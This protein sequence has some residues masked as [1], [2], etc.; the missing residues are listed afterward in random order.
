MNRK[1]VGWG[2]VSVGIL[3]YLIA[4]LN[5]TSTSESINNT[6]AEV[7]EHK[8]LPQ[9]VEQRAESNLP[10][11]NSK[12]PIDPATK[13]RLL[14]AMRETREWLL[15]KGY[16]RG[17][18]LSVYQQYNFSVLEELARNE[19]EKAMWL[20]A[21]RHFQDRHYN[22]AYEIFWKL[23]AKGNLPSLEKLGNLALLRDSPGASLR[24]KQVESGAWYTLAE[25]QGI[26]YV[27]RFQSLKV[28]TADYISQELKNEQGDAEIK[29]R[30]SEILEKLSIEFYRSNESVISKTVESAW[31]QLEEIEKN[32]Y[33]PNM[34]KDDGR[35]LSEVYA[36]EI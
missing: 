20:V 35:R 7:L 15:K 8:P 9:K 22:E 12:K 13:E 21:D 16:Y 19:D 26:D 4:T 25:L 6:P 28:T 30:M 29:R 1:L 31:R 14:Q 10:E 33:D 3:L 23:A 32:Y 17:K 36:K 18:D 24:D 2:V 27:R 34:P 5:F 11:L